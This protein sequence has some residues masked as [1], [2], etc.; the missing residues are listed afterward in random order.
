MSTNVHFFKHIKKQKKIKRLFW[1]PFCVMLYV[2]L[3]GLRY[4]LRYARRYALRYALRY[5]LRHALRYALKP[6]NTSWLSPG[7][8]EA[9]ESPAT[10]ERTSTSQGK[11]NKSQEKV[12]NF[13]RLW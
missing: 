7:T 12:D 2:T 4:I 11:L 5:G 13:Q 6:V 8:P 3:Y 10:Y 9:W 1:S